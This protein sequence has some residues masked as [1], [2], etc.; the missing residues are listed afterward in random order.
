MPEPGERVGPLAITG[1]SSARTKMAGQI[2]TDRRL[3]RRVSD[4][5]KSL[6]NEPYKSKS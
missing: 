4:I 1:L 5:E 2:K 3:K 6:K